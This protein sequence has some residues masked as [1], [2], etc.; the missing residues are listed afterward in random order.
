MGRTLATEVSPRGVRVNAIAPGGMASD[1]MFKALAGN[2]ERPP[3][4]AVR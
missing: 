2:P 4:L 3:I 1:M